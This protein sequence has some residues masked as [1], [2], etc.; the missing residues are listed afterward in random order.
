MRSFP[1][2]VTLALVGIFSLI[3]AVGLA[4]SSLLLLDG[5]VGNLISEAVGILIDVALA[6]L[7]IDRIS[8]AQRRREWDFAYA[9]MIE[10]AA[11]AFVDVMR[12]LYVRASPLFF[13][14]NVLRYEEFVK[15]ATLHISTLRSNIEGF[16]V[17]LT[18]ESHRL[19]RRIELRFL[20][21]IDYITERPSAPV[22][23]ERCFRIMKSIAE[24][25]E[26]FSRKEGEVRYRVEQEIVDAALLRAGVFQGSSGV[27][28]GLDDLVRYRLRVQ[29]ELLRNTSD[30]PNSAIQT[31]RD[32]FDNRYSTYYF[33]LDA[34]LLPVACAMIDGAGGVN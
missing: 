14:N 15:I 32:D 2:R 20:W 7:V 10:S 1:S 27:L 23:D 26:I 13:S 12:I 31:I 18:P 24:E 8:S 19:C 28:Q 17:A 30:L 33:L 21:I 9:V 11:S 5:M 22:I 25:L 3:G 34:K 29:S 4:I 6:S 16:S